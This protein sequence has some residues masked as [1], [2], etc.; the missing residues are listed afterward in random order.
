[1]KIRTLIQR[2]KQALRASTPKQRDKRRHDLKVAQMAAL[3]GRKG[4]AA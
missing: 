3:L 2:R 4:K 1:M